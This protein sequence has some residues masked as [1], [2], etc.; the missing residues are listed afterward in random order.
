MNL[1]EIVEEVAPMLDV[2][3]DKKAALKC[4]LGKGLPRVWA[5]ANQIRQV[6]MNLATNAVESIETKSG[7]ISIRTNTMQC[8]RHYLKETY[9]DEDLSEGTY[10][11]VEVTDSGS[12]MDRETKSKVF[13]PFFTTKL[14]GR[15]LGLSAVLG[16]VRNHRGAIKTYSEPGKGTT[17][18]ILFPAAALVDL[19]KNSS[20][21]A[22][23]NNEERFMTGTVLLVDDDETIREVGREMLK[24]MGMNVLTAED[25]R[26]AVDMYREKADEILCVILDLTMPRM[27]GEE[28]FRELRRIRSDVRVLMSS[29][30]NEQDVSHIFTGKGVAGFIQKPYTSS[31]L[32]EKLQEML[33]AQPSK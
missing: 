30:Y 27:G 16:I 26:I 14:T 15:G 1:S 11:Y 22:E 18:K 25:G 10:T 20:A 28:A 24:S 5:D 8:D 33:E 7:M 32:R 2:V 19:K 9:L 29:G 3:I 23:L 4:E 13:D 6:I 31:N 21:S 12:G 17:F